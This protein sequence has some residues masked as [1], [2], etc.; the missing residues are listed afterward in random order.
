[1]KKVLTSLLL[2]GFA[3]GHSQQ[4]EKA[5][6][7]KMYPDISINPVKQNV[8]GFVKYHF[9]LKEPL[10][11]IRIDGR[12]IEFSEVKINGNPVKFKATDREVLLFEGYEEGEN[13][14][15]SNCEAFQTHAMYFVQKGNS[16]ATQVWT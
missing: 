1:M 5:D 12:K 4:Y 6:F 8:T 2:L 9:E 3:I 14:L 10:D 11:T 16:Q 13:R 15:Q 7:T